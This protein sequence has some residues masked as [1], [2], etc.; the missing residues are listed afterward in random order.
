ML[1]G[2]NP[3]NYPQHVLFGDDTDIPIEYLDTII[4]V[5]SD[6][7]ESFSWAEGDVLLIDNALLSH[8]RMPYTDARKVLV[9]CLK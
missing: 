4:S 1:Y 8:G 6:N 9:S 5:V 2:D 3:L 7:T